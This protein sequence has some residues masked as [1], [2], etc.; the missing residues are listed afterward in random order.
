MRNLEI[1]PLLFGV[2]SLILQFL[3]WIR[4]QSMLAMAKHSL[5]KIAI[6]AITTALLGIVIGIICNQFRIRTT[7]ITVG[8]LV[9]SIALF[10]NNFASL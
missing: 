7:I 2:F 1:A 5:D 4:P 10:L 3:H 8:L 9:C 6:A